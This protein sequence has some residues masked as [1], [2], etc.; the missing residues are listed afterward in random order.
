MK[1]ARRQ[2]QPFLVSC[3][4]LFLSVA[5]A[6][7]ESAVVPGD[8]VGP[9]RLGD[10]RAVT[11]RAMGKPSATK[12]WRPGLVKDSWLGP[13][14]PP[15]SEES[16]IFFNVIYRANRVIQIEFNDPK[17]RTAAGLS[18]ESTLA[19]FRA[20]HQLVSK[21]AYIY[22]DG[23]GSGFVGYYYDDVRQGIA[24]S[25]STQDYFDATMIP[26]ALR[27]HA[28]GR[29]VVPDAGGKRTKANDE[30]PVEKPKS[31]T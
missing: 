3:V 25:F 14:P 10:T 30:R 1:N 29:P 16:P 21:A 28:A 18:I 22:D 9:V 20:K 15:N 6:A 27:V 7:Q 4:I 5:A 24:F 26:E 23:E 2:L 8:R 12:R 31:P 13:E 19:Q 11:I 17:Y